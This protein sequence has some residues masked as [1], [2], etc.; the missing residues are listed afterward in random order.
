MKYVLV[1]MTLLF[2]AAPLSAETTQVTCLDS[3]V[4]VFA[5]TKTMCKKVCEAV[6]LGDAFIKSIDL[7]LPE[8]LTI[9]LFKELP[10]NGQHHSMGYYDSHSNEIRLLD[11]ETALTASMQS[12]PSFGIK[13]SPAIWSSYVIHELAHAAA[14]K[15]FSPG[16]SVCTASEYIAAVVQI[17]TLPLNERK[18]IM[19][20][21][22]EV[23]GF[24][25]KEEITMAYYMFDPSKFMLNA[26]L[27]YS[28]PENG[29]KFIRRLFSEGLSDD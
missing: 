29:L 27:H 1:F 13:M 20:N 5:E 10:S 8:K 15:K 6:Q 16:V 11:Y 21:Y 9:T 22:P 23:A 24:D 4:I 17:S 18:T 14:Q 25:K 3:K 19:Q 2:L 26:Y 28:K 12:P 7:K